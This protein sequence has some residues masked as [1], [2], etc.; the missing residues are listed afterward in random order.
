MQIGRLVDEQVAGVEAVHG[1]GEEPVEFTFVIDGEGG[2]EFE[3]QRVD[4]G[5]VGAG[6]GDVINE[7]GERDEGV[8]VVGTAC[9]DAR[10]ELGLDKTDGEEVSV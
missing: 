2:A 7:G 10:V 3:E 9:V 1:E 6:G 4:S 8:V 5:G